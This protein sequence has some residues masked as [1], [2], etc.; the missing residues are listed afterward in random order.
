MN[1]KT[2]MLT[3]NT[4]RIHG[5]SKTSLETCKDIVDEEFQQ[6]LNFNCRVLPIVE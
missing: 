4:V 1:I 6:L 2:G 3:M 5:N